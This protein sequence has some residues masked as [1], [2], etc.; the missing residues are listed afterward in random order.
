MRAVEWDTTDT[1]DSSV[2]QASVCQEII[3]LSDCSKVLKI[4]ILFRKKAMVG[5][6]FS[7]SSFAM[8]LSEILDKGHRGFSSSAQYAR[9]NDFERHEGRY[10]HR[11]E[12]QHSTA[13]FC[14]VLAFPSERNLPTSSVD[15]VCEVPEIIRLLSDPVNE[16]IMPRADCG[17]AARRCR[18]DFSEG[19]HD[20]AGILRI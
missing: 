17:S 5:N 4:D 3:S 20:S 8:F 9:K 1:S 13:S 15:P 12:R 14:L 7:Y 10:T 18:V 16:N 19:D 6:H 2:A 11:Q